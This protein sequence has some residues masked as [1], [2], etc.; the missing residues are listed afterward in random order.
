[1][2]P[3]RQ[4]ASQFERA[5]D[6][7]MSLLEHLR[8]L[9]TRLFRASLGV[10]GGM[11]IGWF[12]SGRVL[13]IIT[14]PYCQLMAA[15]GK[16]ALAVPGSCNLQQTGITDVFTLRLQLALWVGLIVAGPIWLYQLWA[17]IAPGLHRHERRWA[18]TFAGI[19]APLFA[20]GAVL[21]YFVVAKGLHFLLSFTPSNV[22]TILEVTGYVKFIT[23]FMLLFGVAFEFPL[24]VVLFNVAGI[25]S[26]QRLLS[27]WRTAV[28]I[29]FA[30]SAITVP[31]PD[32][33]GMSAMAICLT[34]LYF[35]AVLFA[36]INDKRRARRH[37]QEYGDLD[38]DEISALD[39][40]VDPVEA[41][42][43][44]DGI[45]PVPPARSLERRY[46]DMT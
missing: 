36:Y 40:D 41:G 1:M 45:E 38:D 17:F 27:W 13:N 35:G 11:L 8:E 39:F 3:R 20:A 4:R 37:R 9:R 28:F 16:P 43:P 29:F 31:T 44:V 26:Y 24:V 19:A 5:A 25:A 15:R 33:F 42:D 30:F 14:D 10:L 46:D 2:L 7:S 34:A 12:L 32:P 18:Y 22:T 21:A 6:G 23:N